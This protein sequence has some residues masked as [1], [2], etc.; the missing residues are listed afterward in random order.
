MSSDFKLAFVSLPVYNGMQTEI[1]GPFYELPDNRSN[2]TNG[3]TQRFW[4]QA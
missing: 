1:H 3:N 4:A 2:K